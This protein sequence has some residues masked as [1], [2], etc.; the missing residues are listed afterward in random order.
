MAKVEAAGQGVFRVSAVLKVLG[1]GPRTGMRL[2]DV[3]SAAKLN[4][5]TAHRLLAALQDVGFV[6]QD[7]DTGLFH[8]SFE[9]FMLGSAAVNRYGFSEIARPHLERLA[10]RTTDTAYISLRSGF[11]AVCVDRQVGSFPIPV[12]IL[13]VGDRRPLGIGGASLAILSFMS[14]DEIEEALEANRDQI[15]TFPRLDISRIWSLVE[16]AR[17]DGYAF[18]DGLVVPEM[19]AVGVPVMNRSG[20]VIAALGVSALRTRLE[21]DRRR[22]IIE[23]MK[24]EARLVEE[25]LASLT[26]ALSASGAE[27]LHQTAL[28]PDLMAPRRVSPAAPERS[29]DARSKRATSTRRRTGRRGAE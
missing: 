17:R 6:E 9:M 27:A 20:R 5:A 25:R 19:S 11:D 4:K 28:A 13:G 16:A 10:N 22:T 3:A 18:F 23:W 29:R 14:D 12:L 21:P 15:E 24:A 1:A 2:T 7:P 8:L 26:G